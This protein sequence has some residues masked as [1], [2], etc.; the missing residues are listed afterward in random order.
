ML[1]GVRT[2]ERGRE[3]TFTTEE[4]ET[5]EGRFADDIAMAVDLGTGWVGNVIDCV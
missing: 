1:A 4:T 5:D 3:R 2:W